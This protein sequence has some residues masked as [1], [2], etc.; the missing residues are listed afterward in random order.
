M[1]ECF[2]QPNGSYN[3]MAIDESEEAYNHH[4][5]RVLLDAAIDYP[6]DLL[7]RAGNCTSIARLRQLIKKPGL[8][9]LSNES[10]LSDDEYE[11]LLDIESYI[12]WTPP[13]HT[14]PWV[15]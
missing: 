6:I 1:F 5:V 15:L 13:H 7:L 10:S 11:D 12:N 2:S 8:L 3:I 14:D 4:V 9:G